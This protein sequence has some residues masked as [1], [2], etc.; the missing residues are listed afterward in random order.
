MK[1]KTIPEL[2][3]EAEERRF[4]SQA[5]STDYVDW[6]KAGEITLPE[7]RPTPKPISLRLPSD[8]SQ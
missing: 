4:W 1:R 8:R 5:D 7:L 2:K 3:D 6:S